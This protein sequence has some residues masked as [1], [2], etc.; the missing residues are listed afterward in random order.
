LMLV[1]V[2]LL[3]HIV[4]RIRLGCVIDASMWFW[5]AWLRQCAQR[6]AASVR[7]LA[8]FVVL[9]ASRVSAVPGAYGGFAGAL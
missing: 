7:R 2:P 5:D 3:I 6:G 1:V 8:D 4:P 9:V